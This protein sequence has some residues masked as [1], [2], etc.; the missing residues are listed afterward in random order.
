MTNQPLTTRLAL[1][2]AALPLA[3]SGCSSM[4]MG[5]P[6]AKTSATGAAGGET[7]QNANSKLERCSASLGTLAVVEDNNADWFQT[8]RNAK[9]G[10]TTPVLRMLVQQSNCFVIV[11]RGRSMQNMQHERALASSGE[12][13][14]GSNIGKGQMVAADFT[15]NPTVTFSNNDSGGI[16]GAIG[17]LLP[18]MGGRVVGAVA[19]NAKFKEA[20]TMLTLIDNRSG[21]QLAAAEGS[22]KNVDFGAIGGAFG[23]ALG[24][25]G[26]GYSNTAEGK[27]I[28][29]AFTDS[30]NNMV[31]A[32]RSYKAQDVK[33]GLGRGGTLKVN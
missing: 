17:G 22:A 10:P 9:L 8:L 21:V 1:L 16:G 23:S 32:V 24:A 28:V 25:T 13:R 30:Y 15:M 7:S 3:L 26:G 19:G 11:E 33:G 14:A 29:S 2:C 18:G 4:N 6:S 27:V 20:S 5:A 12:T 31:R